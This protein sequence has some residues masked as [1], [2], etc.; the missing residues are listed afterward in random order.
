M[1]SYNRLANDVD[2][3]AQRFRSPGGIRDVTIESNHDAEDRFEDPVPSDLGGGPIL[4]DATVAEEDGDDAQ[5]A[6]SPVSF[7]GIGLPVQS[8]DKESQS[9][10]EFEDEQACH[11]LGRQRRAT[12]NR[13]K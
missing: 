1:R 12:E 13:V 4:E 6:L 10:S 5:Y 11:E 3:K 9:C 2:G 7:G 8:D